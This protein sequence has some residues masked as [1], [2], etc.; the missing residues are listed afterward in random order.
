MKVRFFTNLHTLFVLS[1]SVL[2]GL[3]LMVEIMVSELPIARSISIGD[4][5][6]DWK[7]HCSTCSECYW[8]LSNF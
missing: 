7:M 3:F 5:L 1:I 2:R 4:E 6:V 8:L